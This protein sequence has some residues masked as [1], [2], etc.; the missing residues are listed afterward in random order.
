[1]APKIFQRFMR[2]RS[3]NQDLEIVSRAGEE[4]QRKRTGHSRRSQSPT[5]F[6]V[7]INKGYR[8]Q[9][10][11]QKPNSCMQRPDA[12]R[13]SCTKITH[14]VVA[15]VREPSLRCE[16]PISLKSQSWEDTVEE[17]DRR[18]SAN[19]RYSTQSSAMDVSH[20]TSRQSMSDSSLAESYI[21]DEA[22][23]R[24]RS[25]NYSRDGT[26]SAT[27]SVQN[28][29]SELSSS[30]LSPKSLSPVEYQQVQNNLEHAQHE[31]SGSLGL[32]SNDPSFH[33]RSSSIDSCSSIDDDAVKE[34]TVATHYARTL[35]VLEGRPFRPT[36]R[37]HDDF[38][39]IPLRNGSRHSQVMRS[40][41]V[42]PTD[43]RQ[44]QYTDN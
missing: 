13:K 36:T 33:P 8:A 37:H 6:D 18:R 29:C 43:E 31:Y 3:S 25:L 34:E 32:P 42:D 12:I 9:Q 2:K 5:G 22:V 30:I 10:V 17:A 27:P 35:A 19:Q 39:L 26:R 11:R 40:P 28:N 15:E 16:S 1:M 21:D 4:A 38:L 24:P 20:N 7:V 14:P 44:I 41:P 23:G